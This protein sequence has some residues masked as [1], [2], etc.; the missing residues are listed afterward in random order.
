MSGGGHGWPPCKARLEG[1]DRISGTYSLTTC[2]AKALRQIIEQLDA[3][4]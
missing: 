2:E 1:A 3:E 4:P